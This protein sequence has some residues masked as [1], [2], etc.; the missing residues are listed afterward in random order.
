M[1]GV[2]EVEWGYLAKRAA[3][4]ERDGTQREQ[5]PQSTQLVLGHRARLVAGHSYQLRVQL[6]SQFRSLNAVTDETS[7]QRRATAAD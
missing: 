4:T 1:C 5:R 7:D 3:G 2:C 6:V